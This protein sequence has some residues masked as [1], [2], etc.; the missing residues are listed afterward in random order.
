MGHHDDGATILTVQFVEQFHNLGTH[1]RVEV[2]S[3]LVG[4]Q[5]LWVANDGTGDG[6]TLAL[7][8]R[9]LCGTVLHAMAETHAL[10]DLLGQLDALAAAHATIDK[11]QLYVVKHVECG[12]EVEALEHE[13][14]RL[15]AQ[16]GQLIV[17]QFGVDACATQLN[18]AAGGL[19]EQSHDVQQR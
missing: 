3:G 7:S 16:F 12:D 8:A 18:L 19:V 9:E 5:N 2:T 14:Q 10:D 4:Q 17:A 13:A 15:V 11:G 6:H 1:L